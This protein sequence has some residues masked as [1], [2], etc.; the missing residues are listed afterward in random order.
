MRKLKDKTLREVAELTGMDVSYISRLETDSLE[1][2]PTRE[3][4]NKLTKALD[5]SREE[6][7]ELIAAA[8]RLNDELIELS[9]IAKERPMVG[10]LFHAAVHLSPEKLEELVARFESEI[11]ESE[12]KKRKKKS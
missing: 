11:D 1:S 12:Q 10:K 6:Q 9:R 5:C 7:G 3:T 8:E 4:I 2:K